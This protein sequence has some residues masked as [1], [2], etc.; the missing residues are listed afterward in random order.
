MLLMFTV[1]LVN[2]YLQGISKFGHFTEEQ[3]LAMLTFH[4]F[5]IKLATEDLKKYRP[6]D[7]KWCDNDR[8]AF[9]NA[10]KLHGKNFSKLQEA[11]NHRS[12]ADVISFY[13]R[14]K[15]QSIKTT[16]MTEYINQMTN[17]QD[18]YVRS[19][20]F[21]MSLSEGYFSEMFF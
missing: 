8:V 16:V 11:V 13:Y 2:D 12:L 6:I 3:A 19:V 14:W 4:N 9:E 18:G 10:F 20:S 5:D 1:F 7:N 15:K 21:I 17:K